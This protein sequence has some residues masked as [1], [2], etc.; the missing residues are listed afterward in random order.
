MFDYENGIYI[1]GRRHDDDGWAW[2]PH[3]NYH[4]RG[5]EW[6]REMHISYFQENGELVLDTDAGMRMRGLGSTSNPQK[7]FNVYFRNDYGLKV[8][9]LSLFP[10]S[11]SEKFK[12][13]TFRNSG[14]DFLQT[15]FKDALL[16][17]I[18]EPLDLDLQAFKPAILY[19]NG[20]YWGIHNIREKY[21][22]H[23]FNY[24]YGVDPDEVNVLGICGEI[25]EGENSE[26]LELLT[27]LNDHDLD[28]QENYD[29]VSDTV[30]YTHLTLPTSDLV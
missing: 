6:E 19:I 25:E 5:I 12:R 26:Y 29:Y 30:S 3:G 20:E 23:H 13:L 15:H 9:N 10:D 1:P 24:Q 27:Y 11:A 21:D 17:R 4:N 7:S 22:E 16:Q 14:H 28:D 8:A 2:W 18:A